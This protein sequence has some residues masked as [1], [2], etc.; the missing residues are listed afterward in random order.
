VLPSTPGSDSAL[1]A[2]RIPRRLPFLTRRVADGSHRIYL[3]GDLADVTFDAK[4][5]AFKGIASAR[6]WQENN[7][8]RSTSE[9]AFWGF[10][11]PAVRQL[12]REPFDGPPTTVASGR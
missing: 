2:N 12:L 7:P 11:V 1:L 6:L 8:S 9:S 4:W 5:Y 10:Y 3:A